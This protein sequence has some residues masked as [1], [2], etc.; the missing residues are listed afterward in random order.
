MKRIDAFIPF[1]D[2]EQV[3]I[4][5][6][7]LRGS[8]SIGKIF[9]LTPERCDRIPEGCIAIPVDT[10][11]SSSTV[12]QIAERSEADF[13]L[14]YLK[15]TPLKPGYFAFERMVRIAEECGAGM[16]YADHYAIINGERCPHPVIDYQEG[17]LRDDFN[18]GSLLLYDSAALKRAA[19]RMER[20]NTDMPDLRLRLKVSQQ[21]Q[22]VHIN[23]YLYSEVEE[24]TRLRTED[25]RLRGPQEQGGPTGDGTGLHP[26]PEGCGGIPN[27]YSRRLTWKRVILTSRRRSSRS[28]TASE[29]SVMPSFRCYVRR[30]IF[31]ST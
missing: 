24:D 2:P 5:V 15:Q 7:E 31:P 27:P 16:V 28:A 3:K 4:T 18:F 23:E 6:E 22:L 11:R 17:S 21:H 9:L 10:L 12:K 29:P 13:T 20:E 25:F 1:T 26:T 19:Q 14:I 30:P 8:G